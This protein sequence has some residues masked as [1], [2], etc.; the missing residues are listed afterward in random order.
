MEG[1]VMVSAPTYAA[2]LERCQRAQSL[3]DFPQVDL[4]QF[5][6]TSDAEDR[7]LPVRELVDFVLTA[8][9]GDERTEASLGALSLV[10]AAIRDLGCLLSTVDHAQLVACRGH[11]LQQLA[12]RKPQGPDHSILMAAMAAF[13]DAAVQL[14]LEGF[15]SALRRHFAWRAANLSVELGDAEN[16]AACL[17]MALAGPVQSATQGLYFQC[18]T[19]LLRLAPGIVHRVLAAVQD[20]LRRAWVRLPAK[21]MSKRIPVGSQQQ[22][23]LEPLAE[24]PSTSTFADS[25]SEWAPRD[26]LGISILLLCIVEEPLKAAV[27]SQEAHALLSSLRRVRDDSHLD[28]LRRALENAPYVS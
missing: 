20:D 26:R 3:P 16:A 8:C 28:V 27:Y 18:A 7:D 10:G 2:L 25:R 1:K 13:K 15:P 5:F 21:Q 11:L 19:R 6:S 14:P 24:E 9:T 17:Q 4:G 23:L 12:Y 22:R